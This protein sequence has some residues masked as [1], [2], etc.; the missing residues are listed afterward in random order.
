MNHRSLHNKDYFGYTARLVVKYSGVSAICRVKLELMVSDG[1]QAAQAAATN[2]CRDSA[3][4][5]Y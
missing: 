3:L 2:E 4:L 1:T 5:G